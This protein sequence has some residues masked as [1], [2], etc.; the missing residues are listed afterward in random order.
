MS[1]INSRLAKIN[2]EFFEYECKFKERYGCNFYVIV[3]KKTGKINLIRNH[4]NCANQN[5]QFIENKELIVDSGNQNEIC[6]VD[7][8][9]MHDISEINLNMSEFL[10][11]STILDFAFVM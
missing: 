7:S 4:N 2:E 1:N 6:H 5:R 8:K 3:D 11:E 9:K 10:D